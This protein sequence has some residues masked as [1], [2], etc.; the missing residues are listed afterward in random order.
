MAG[1]K[2]CFN[3]YPKWLENSYRLQAICLKTNSKRAPRAR[4]ERLQPGLLQDFPGCAKACRYIF[5]TEGLSAAEFAKFQR[6][7]VLLMDLPPP[8]LP[9]GRYGESN[10]LG[11]C[12][13]K[14]GRRTSATLRWKLR[15]GR[16]FLAADTKTR[17]RVSCGDV[18]ELMPLCLTLPRRANAQ[19][20]TLNGG[21]RDETARWSMI[22]ASGPS[23]GTVQR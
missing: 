7:T 13:M 14:T 19:E 10:P 8:Q 1:A 20:L 4:P 23:R 9:L 2:E 21:T 22:G 5:P 11:V 3:E 18:Q 16:R 17:L 6:T 12:A 15:A